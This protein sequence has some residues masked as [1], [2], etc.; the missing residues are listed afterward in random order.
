VLVLSEVCSF[1]AVSLTCE[2]MYP[3]RQNGWYKLAAKPDRNIA[4]KTFF[5]FKRNVMNNIAFSSVHG[6]VGCAKN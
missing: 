1:E 3:L 5:T 2:A 6:V 4:L